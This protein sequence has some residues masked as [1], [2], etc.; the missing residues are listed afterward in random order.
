MCAL[1]D[2]RFVLPASICDTHK[3]GRNP[4]HFHELYIDS[5]LIETLVHPMN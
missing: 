1:P 2:P 4:L 3:A 5:L